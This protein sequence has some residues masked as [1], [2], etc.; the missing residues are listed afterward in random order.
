V[1]QFFYVKLVQQAGG[2][3]RYNNEQEHQHTSHVTQF[4]YVKL[5]QQAG[6]THR[7]NKDVVKKGGNVENL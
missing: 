1:T 5:V 6:G 7:Y 2:I 3:H 4:F